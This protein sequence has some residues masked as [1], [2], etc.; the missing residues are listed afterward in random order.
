MAKILAFARLSPL[1]D[2]DE[3]QDSQTL[4][5]LQEGQRVPLKARPPEGKK[6]SPPSRY[7]EATLVQ[8]MEKAGIGPPSTYAQTLGTL[9]AREYARLSGRHLA[10]TAVGLLV[11]TYLARQVP[12]VLQQDFTATMETG[13]DDVAAGQTSRVEYLTRFWTEGLAPTIGRA[14]RDAPDLPLPHLEATRLRATPS[15]P[16]LVR[17]GRACRFRWKSFPPTS[18]R[19]RRTPS[20]RAPGHRESPGWGVTAVRT[21]RTCPKS[22]RANARRQ[23][24]QDRRSAARRGAL[25]GNEVPPSGAAA[26]LAHTPS[27]SRPHHSSVTLLVAAYAA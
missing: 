19:R 15:G 26:P 8:A 18:A 16:H 27:M 21:R 6:T 11:T 9:Q 5:P 1:R 7:T 24:P 10:V 12:Q 2:E 25:Q 4:P 20:C 3:D 17:G 14:S 13:L 22:A 23:V